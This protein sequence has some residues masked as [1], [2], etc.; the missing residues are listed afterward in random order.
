MLE[1]L[2]CMRAS[3]KLEGIAWISAAPSA[4]VKM[5]FSTLLAN[6]HMLNRIY[7][8]TVLI[9][10]HI[11]CV[12]LLFQHHFGNQQHNNFPRL[13]IIFFGIESFSAFLGY[14]LAWSG[15]HLIASL[16][17]LGFLL[18]I[19]YSIG[20]SRSPHSSTV[21]TWHFWDKSKVDCRL[22][23]FRYEK[24]TPPPHATQA[25]RSNKQGRA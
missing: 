9:P 4:I 24:T 15:P 25:H 14:V 20:S 17:L 5:F 23:P 19:T 6:L 1:E 10:A 7:D 13:F 11:P 18:V 12:S 2:K 22:L 3:D 8:Q 16:L 21:L